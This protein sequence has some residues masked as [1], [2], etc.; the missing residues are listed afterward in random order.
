LEIREWALE[1]VVIVLFQL[2]KEKGKSDLTLED[3]REFCSKLKCDE[4]KW[5][6]ITEQG[7]LKE[8][9][10]TEWYAINFVD[11]TFPGYNGWPE[12][13]PVRNYGNKINLNS[14]NGNGN[15]E[16]VNENAN[17]EK[18]MKMLK[19]FV[20]N[21][22]KMDSLV[23]YLKLD[24]DDGQNHR[25]NI[26]E[27]E[28]DYWTLTAEVIGPDIVFPNGPLKEQAEKLLNSKE[29][30]DQGCLAQIVTGIVRGSRDWDFKS[31]KLVWAWASNI[32]VEAIG[33]ILVE[34]RGDWITCLILMTKERDPR[35][36]IWLI[37]LFLG[38]LS[39]STNS[40]SFRD[41]NYLSAL[42]SV[43]ISMSWKTPYV[44]SEVCRLIKNFMDHQSKDIRTPVANILA[45]VH[46]FCWD[47]S[48][49]DVG[50]L[51]L[52]PLLEP[53]FQKLMV[54]NLNLS[55]KRDSK[56]EEEIATTVA[57]EE[58]IESCA[59]TMMRESFLRT[60]LDDE[61]TT[62]LEL[63]EEKGEI[64]RK[65]S[66]QKSSSCLIRQVGSVLKFA[67]D[68][69]SLKNLFGTVKRGS[70]MYDARE[71]E[72]YKAAMVLCKTTM[73]FLVRLSSIN[74][75][76]LGDAF[77][78]LFPCLCSLSADE[79]MDE[80][81]KALARSSRRVILSTRLTKQGLNFML[82]ILEKCA[83]ESLGHSRLMAANSIPVFVT[84]NI[85]LLKNK[86][87][88]VED[89]KDMILKLL[90][91]ERLDV[92]QEARQALSSLIHFRFLPVTNKLITELK[93][94][95]DIDITSSATR[96][97]TANIN[98]ARMHK[99]HGGILGLTAIVLAYPYS[100]P[101]F[102]PKILIALSRHTHDRNPVKMSVTHCFSEFRRTHMDNWAED[103]LKF[104]EEERQVLVDVLV[105][106]SYYV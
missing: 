54:L 60:N 18:R 77:I 80:D 51:R 46:S 3:L 29:N 4:R 45:H 82:K 39:S 8:P 87:K 81:L 97:A 52:A 101:R 40:N 79:K 106:P 53:L 2:K 98:E 75:G 12:K 23:S 103:R 15:N 78:P 104:T 13:I 50:F 61:H 11:K 57:V 44:Y 47:M 102:L 83:S 62:D 16:N 71:T 38:H 30:K 67:L 27:D 10:E 56:E 41:S 14:Q 93:N 43:L 48:V 34:T 64:I 91:D 49:V 22:K 25:G 65:E 55:P 73:A 20:T 26:N 63:M 96:N 74:L 66:K 100:V 19:D 5:C 92:R 1:T 89:V 68:K 105:S 9:S 59:P 33:N 36:L 37:N 7:N 32:L 95:S 35:R 28:T 72:V 99:C 17:D 90:I 86:E 94:L 42:H 76:G 84:S 88:Y 21:S 69:P 31:Q 58:D 24:L 6:L 85:F 70:S